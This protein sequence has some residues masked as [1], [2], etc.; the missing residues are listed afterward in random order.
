[1]TEISEERRTSAERRYVRFAVIGDRAGGWPRTLAGVLAA[2]HD[3]S[4]YDA[5]AAGATAYDVRRVQL[6]EAV[7]HR[8]HLVAL[9]AG[10]SGRDWD[11]SEVR[12]HLTHCARVLTQRGAVLLTTGVGR[13]V[14]WHRRRASELDGIYDELAQRFGSLHLD[15]ASS[16]AAVANGFAGALHL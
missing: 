8:P 9:K 10:V 11:V 2:A 12:S 13:Q 7:A 1:M 16:A 4:W 3:V 15:H 14:R 5:S 6:R